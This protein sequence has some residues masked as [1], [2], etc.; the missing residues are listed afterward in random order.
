[1]GKGSQESWVSVNWETGQGFSKGRK[2]CFGP[3]LQKKRLKRCCVMRPVHSQDVKA[4]QLL[5]QLQKRYKAC[6]AFEMGDLITT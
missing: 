1:M 3:G 5:E 2:D 6:A 4:M